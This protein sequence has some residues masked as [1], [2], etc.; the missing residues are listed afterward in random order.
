M[1][2]QGWKHAAK[3]LEFVQPG[4]ATRLSRLSPSSTVKIQLHARDHAYI[5]AVCFGGDSPLDKS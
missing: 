4:V 1:T 2:V 5:H 3:T